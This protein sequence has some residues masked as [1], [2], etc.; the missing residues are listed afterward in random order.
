VSCSAWPAVQ[1]AAPPSRVVIDSREVRPGDLFVGLPGRRHD[2]G[3]FAAAVR[4]DNLF[5]CQFHPEKSQAVGLK[6]LEN[7]V[8]SG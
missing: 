6:L 1:W 8:A 5:A 4:K 2:G 3:E 7:F